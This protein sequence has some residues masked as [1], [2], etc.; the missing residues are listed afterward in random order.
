[1]DFIYGMALNHYSKFS[2]SS[3]EVNVWSTMLSLSTTEN[4]GIIECTVQG[5]KY[6]CTKN[7][8]NTGQAVSVQTE[9]MTLFCLTDRL[10]VVLSFFSVFYFCVLYKTKVLLLSCLS[11]VSAQ[12]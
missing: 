11:S 5:K 10:K 12:D 3:S 8:E 2:L 1:M 7:H 6:M 9:R 4:A